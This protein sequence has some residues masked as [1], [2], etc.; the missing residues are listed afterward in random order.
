MNKISGNR[1]TFIY[2]FMQI[3]FKI[4][5]FIQQHVVVTLVRQNAYYG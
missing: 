3:N 2:P 4:L 1:L 5:L